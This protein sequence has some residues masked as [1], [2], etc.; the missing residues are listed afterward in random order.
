MKINWI[1]AICILI[2]SAQSIAASDNVIITGDVESIPDSTEV[3]LF[4]HEGRVGMGK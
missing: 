1:F 2:S 3:I 4:R